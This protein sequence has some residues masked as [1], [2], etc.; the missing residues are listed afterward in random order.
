MKR[1][2]ICCIAVLMG[3]TCFAGDG[4]AIAQR[5]LVLSFRHMIGANELVLG[6]AFVNSMGDTISVQRFKYYLSNFSIIDDKGKTIQIPA[7]YFLVDEADPSSKTITLTVPDIAIT[8]IRFIIGVDSIKNVSGI[9]TGVLDPLKGMFWT[10]NSGYV[11]AKIEGQSS[12]STIAGQSFTY[13]IGGFRTPMNVLRS[14]SF[15][16]QGNDRPKNITIKADINQWFKGKSELKITETPVCHSPGSL[17]MRIADNYSTM[18]S[19]NSIQ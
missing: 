15:S 7:T 14:V 5:S 19:I 3:I 8:G 16:T 1:S 12:A 11:M 6:D 10:W 17:A 4:K 9:Q 13:H 18:F 2:A